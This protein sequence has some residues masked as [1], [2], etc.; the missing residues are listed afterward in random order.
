[1]LLG[2]PFL[3]F[4]LRFAKRWTRAAKAAEPPLIRTYA[5]NGRRLSDSS[6]ERAERLIELGKVVARRDRR[7]RIRLIQFKHD[8]GAYP[9]QAT[10]HMGTRYSYEEP[11]PSGH[12]AWK[13]RELVRDE[14]SL[15]A[16]FGE[17]P[18]DREEAD[19]FVRAIFRAVPLSCMTKP[20]KLAPVVNIEEYRE[21]RRLEVLDKLAAQ[22][23]QAA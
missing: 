13:H 17:K 12:Y 16:L 5:A 9:L 6:P 7:G 19:R 20:N 1:L 23:R 4:V 18:D 21:R 2:A 8:C 3:F 11:L 22:K 15:E 10:A 14:R